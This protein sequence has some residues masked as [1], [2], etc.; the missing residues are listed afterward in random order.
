M[1]KNLTIYRIA[2]GWAPALEAMET[3]LQA[4]QFVPIGATQD[5]AVGW[6]P[7]RGNEHDAMVEA[8]AGQRIMK[9]RI[10][11]KSVPGAAVR[12]KAQAEADHIE[13]TTGRKPGKKQMKELREDALLALLPQAFPRQS[14]VLVWID[15]AAGLLMTDASS[16]GKLDEVVTALV[17]AFN[18]LSL[19]L[20]QTAVTPQSAMTSWLSAPD[21]ADNLFVDDGFAIERACELR[22]ADEEKSVVKFNRHNLVTDEVRK[23]ITEGKLPKWAAMSWEGRVGFVLDDC[24]RLKRIAFLEGVFDDRADDGESGFDTDVALATGE[25]RKLIPALV[26]ALGGEIHPGAALLDA[27]ASGVTIYTDGQPDPLLEQARALVVAEQKPSISYIQR[28]LQIGYNRAA[29]LLEDLEKL[30]VVSPMHS[31]GQRDVLTKS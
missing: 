7:P 18:D 22:S 17:Q 26:G 16:Q 25:L 23:H 15:P 5:K 3:A 13:A 8:V 14:S 1:F 10:E 27:P 9:L 24:M 2:A 29:S 31:S 28:K 12:E 4:A 11:T 19:T 21:D 30:G 6:V 20:L